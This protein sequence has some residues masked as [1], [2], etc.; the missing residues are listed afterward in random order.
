MDSKDTWDMTFCSYMKMKKI[1]FIPIVESP[2]LITR[3]SDPALRCFYGHTV[4]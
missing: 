3:P 4:T 1:N 2:H